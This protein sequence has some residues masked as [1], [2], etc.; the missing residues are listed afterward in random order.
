MMLRLLRLSRL[1]R[2]T[3]LLLAAGLALGGGTAS[4]AAYDDFIQAVQKS[5]PAEV[6]ALLKRGMDAN[7]VDRTGQPVLHI[8]AREGNLEVLRVLVQAGA[9]ID[10]RN[11]MKET[12]IML[13]A[14]GGHVKLVEFLISREAQINHPGWTPLLY[15][16]TNG[17]TEVIKVLLENHAYIDS[18]SPNGSTPI[19]MAIRGG[20]Q[21]AARLL[22]DEGADPAVK[23]ENGENAL[24]WADKGKQTDLADAMRA[25]MRARRP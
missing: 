23:N 19:M 2:V 20:H 14:L 9:D 21:A 13:A 6:V 16:A 22:L 17:Q 18:S 10:K 5:N 4:A 3:P 25:K 11:A 15:A 1:A 24:T 8:A 12:P 7:T